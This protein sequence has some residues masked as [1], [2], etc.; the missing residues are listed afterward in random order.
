MNPSNMKQYNELLW[1]GVPKSKRTDVRGMTHTRYVD[2][3]HVC[4]VELLRAVDPEEPFRFSQ[5]CGE[6]EEYEVRRPETDTG[7]MQSV[8]IP[9]DYLRRI[10]DNVTSDNV[11]LHV[12]TNFPLRMTWQDKEDT[13]TAWIAPLIENE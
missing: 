11:A 2:P 1:L 3:G 9:V 4:Y 8:I 7:M 13:W 10:I 12:T 5:Y 6:K